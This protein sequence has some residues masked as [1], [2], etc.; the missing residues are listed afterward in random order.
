MFRLSYYHIINSKSIGEVNL[1]LL[2]SRTTNT[3][4][5]PGSQSI[6]TAV[7]SIKYK[8]KYSNFSFNKSKK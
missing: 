6:S 5:T 8:L 4:L 2:P 7:S 1:E 3:Q